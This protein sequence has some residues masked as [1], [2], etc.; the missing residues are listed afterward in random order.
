MESEEPRGNKKVPKVLKTSKI[1]KILKSTN[2][3]KNKKVSEIKY[4]RAKVPSRT[5]MHKI[6]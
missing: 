1:P 5:K 4:T 3:F 2:N 6:T